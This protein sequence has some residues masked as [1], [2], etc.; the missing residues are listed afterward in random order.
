[1]TPD[2]EYY[3]VSA[4]YL[5]PFTA[6]DYNKIKRNITASMQKKINNSSLKINAENR[7]ISEL[8]QFYA[9]TNSLG[10][11]LVYEEKTIGSLEELQ[12]GTRALLD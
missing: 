9:L 3:D 4:D 10:W 7:L 8:A 11:T 6:E 5:N 12:Q 2:F 1:M